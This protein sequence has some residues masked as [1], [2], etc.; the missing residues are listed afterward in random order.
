MPWFICLV[1][2][3][4]VLFTSH[5][6]FFPFH[7]FYTGKKTEPRNFRELKTCKSIQ[8][9][10]VNCVFLLGKGSVF[11]QGLC[12]HHVRDGCAETGCQHR[13]SGYSP[14]ETEVLYLPNPH[15]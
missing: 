13:H 15:H 5:F 4:R 14:R 7:D 3:R 11:P 6:I 9:F 10:G 8:K 2:R 1:L 12:F